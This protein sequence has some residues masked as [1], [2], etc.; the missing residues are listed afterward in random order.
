MASAVYYVLL[1]DGDWKIQLNGRHF[2]P[3]PSRDLAV[4]VA[5]AAAKKA[6]ARGYA[7]RVVVQ[8]GTLFRTQWSAWDQEESQR[9]R[10]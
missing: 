2:G 10:A 1:R 9:L 8:D 4:E 3:C 7:S 5:L 6:A